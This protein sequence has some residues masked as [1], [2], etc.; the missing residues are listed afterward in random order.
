MLKLNVPRAK[1]LLLAEPFPDR[2][3]LS[4]YVGDG[5]VPHQMASEQHATSEYW[6]TCSGAVPDLGDRQPSAPARTKPPS[7]TGLGVG[8]GGLSL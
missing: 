3:R 5:S 6:C 8:G 4:S 1:C 2:L 7:V